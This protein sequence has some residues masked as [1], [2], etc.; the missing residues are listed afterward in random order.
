MTSGQLEQSVIGGHKP[1]CRRSFR[2][3]KMEGIERTESER[4][5]RTSAVGDCATCCYRHRGG[6][7][8]QPRCKP[9]VLTR[10]AIVLEVVSRRVHQFQGASLGQ[11]QNRGH[12][13]G[14]PTD[15][16]RCGV[17]EGT[18]ETADVEVCDHRHIIIVLPATFEILSHSWLTRT[19]R[20]LLG[21]ERFGAQVRPLPIDVF[22]NVLIVWSCEHLDVQQPQTPP[23]EEQQPCFFAQLVQVGENVPS[24]QRNVPPGCG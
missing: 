8:P 5:Q 13:L 11:L 22:E 19:L 21:A 9:P 3:R 18:L 16:V 4:S 17:V 10:I 15:S 7:K 14:F 23:C 1:S 2:K 12:T 6:F 20:Y 24:Q